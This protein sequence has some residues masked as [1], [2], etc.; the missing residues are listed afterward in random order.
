[1]YYFFKKRKVKQEKFFFFSSRRRHTRWNCDWSSDVCSSDLGP[2]PDDRSGYSLDR[3]GP[4]ESPERRRGAGRDRVRQEPLAAIRRG[5][6]AQGPRDP[7]GAD[8]N[9]GGRRARRSSL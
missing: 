9:A 1:M 8:R 6:G 5:G 7:D 2:R 3:D 4:A